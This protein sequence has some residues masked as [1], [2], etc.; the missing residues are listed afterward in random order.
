MTRW[1]EIADFPSYSVSNEGEVRNDNTERIIRQA[2]TR[3]GTAYVGLMDRGTQRKRAVA[4][5]VA[6]AFLLVK[7][8]P[9]F[10][11]PINLNGDRL[12]NQV[13]NL[14]WRTRRFAAQYVQQFNYY[15][16]DY[17][18]VEEMD[19]RSEFETSWDAATTYGLLDRDIRESTTNRSRVWPTW[20][21]FR[22]LR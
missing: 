20:Q 3:S 14:S 12:D 13:T 19:T 11:T 10:N 17:G 2:Q 7:P 1:R 9:T 18:P 16:L 8:F 5:L 21:R 15:T 22:L 4:L 6:S